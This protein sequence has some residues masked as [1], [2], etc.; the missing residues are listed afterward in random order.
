M[1]NFWRILLLVWVLSLALAEMPVAA[2][3]NQL[4]DVELCSGFDACEKE[5]YA[6]HG[7]QDNY[8]RPH[9]R[10]FSGHNCTNYAS[11]MMAKLGATAPGGLMGNGADW[12][13]SAV[14]TYSI[15][16]QSRVPQRRMIAQWNA[17][18]GFAGGAGHVAFVERVTS[19]YIV[20]SEDNYGGTFKWRKIYRS[21]ENWPSSFLRFD[22]V[23][24]DRSYRNFNGSGGDD[25]LLYGADSARD[26]VLYG[27]DNHNHMFTMNEVD[28]DGRYDLIAKGDFN[29]D[30][31]A[32]LLFYGEGDR[33][34]A[35]WYGSATR[36]VST[37]PRMCRWTASTM[38]YFRVTSTVT[39]EVTFSGMVKGLERMHCGLGRLRRY[40]GVKLSM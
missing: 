27:S 3:S 25:V 31:F 5:G 15:A 36:G 6:H 40:H 29:G 9:W 16:V 21:S 8:Q 37:R 14:K 38:L 26:V 28:I 22:G 10:A 13:N 33:R 11:Y 4:A 32:D 12:Y 19:R 7:Y 30:T 1:K 24:A 2:H 20:T 34:D 39:G 17:N 35:L 23:Q 18:S